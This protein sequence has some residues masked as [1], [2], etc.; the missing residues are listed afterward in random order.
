MIRCFA[1]SVKALQSLEHA[2]FPK[3]IR[4]QLGRTVNG[5]GLEHAPFPK[6]IRSESF[7]DLSAASLEHAPF[8]KV[9]RFGR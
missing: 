6:V 5:T 4:Y 2:P 7:I 1:D 3:V 8:P 9:I